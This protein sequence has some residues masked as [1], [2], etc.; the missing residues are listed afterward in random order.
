MQIYTLCW[1]TQCA[2]LFSGQGASPWLSHPS[3]PSTPTRSARALVM[4]QLPL[5]GLCFGCRTTTV[6]WDTQLQGFSRVKVQHPGRAIDSLN[7]G[8]EAELQL[9]WDTQLQGFS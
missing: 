5:S 8:L 7:F 3:H 4:G 2:G 1:D 6:C 9:C